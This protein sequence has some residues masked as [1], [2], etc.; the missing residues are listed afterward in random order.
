M[1]HMVTELLD[2]LRH[3]PLPLS[4]NTM[5]IQ[6]PAAHLDGLVGVH[7]AALRQPQRRLHLQ[8]EVQ[9]ISACQDCLALF[10]LPEVSNEWCKDFEVLT[11]SHFRSWNRQL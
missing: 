10:P 2:I 11:D 4:P 8:I 9:K 1:H 7:E 5:S 3:F 6:Q